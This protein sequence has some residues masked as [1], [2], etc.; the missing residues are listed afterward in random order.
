MASCNFTDGAVDLVP[1]WVMLM[2]N[3]LV[4]ANLPA[5]IVESFMPTVMGIAGSGGLV[6]AYPLYPLLSQVIFNFYLFGCL[7]PG[8]Q[9]F[10]CFKLGF[11]ARNTV[12]PW[13]QFRRAWEHSWDAYYDDPS[14][15]VPTASGVAPKCWVRKAMSA[16][17]EDTQ[18]V[19]CNETDTHAQL[20]RSKDGELLVI[21]FRG[22]GSLT[23]VG[24][25]CSFSRSE[26]YCAMGNGLVFENEDALQS[27]QRVARTGKQATQ[28]LRNQSS[29][30]VRACTSTCCL[31][32][33]EE[34]IMP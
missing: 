23:N 22:T 20:S 5:T 12:L 2:A 25:D 15:E 7:P 10:L 17:V 33:R 16:E 4:R 6:A 13:E 14:I 11:V 9:S 31:C 34:S 18:L 8:L 29:S 32:I 26:M 19:S 21:A 24:T 30:M 27:T 3:F 28:A 1:R